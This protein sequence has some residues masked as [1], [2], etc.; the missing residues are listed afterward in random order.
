MTLYTCKTT[1][2]TFSAKEV[3]EISGVSGATQRDWRRRNFIGKI[4]GGGRAKFSLDDLIELTT[5]HALTSGGIPLPQAFDLASLAILP[6]IAN[7]ARW[8]DDVTVFAGD[9]ISD[10]EKGRALSGLVKGVSDDDNWLFAVIGSSQP[11]MGR[12]DDL[13][14]LDGGMR[15]RPCA[16]VID[17][18]GIAHIIA[19]A[20]PLPLITLEIENTE[21]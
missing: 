10:E 3:E 9:P 14:K 4:Q 2:R 21:Q 1:T 19:A 16:I 7:F 15:G 12:T 6:V 8:K 18:T 13:R 17:L 20:A 11:I 5:V